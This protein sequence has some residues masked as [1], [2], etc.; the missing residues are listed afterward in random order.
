MEMEHICLLGSW[1]VWSMRGHRWESLRKIEIQKKTKYG[2]S[3]IATL[4]FTIGTEKM[5]TINFEQTGCEGSI[6][7][8]FEKRKVPFTCITGVNDCPDLL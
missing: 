7:A 2:I 3:K 8:L 4:K 6:L 1:T 5:I